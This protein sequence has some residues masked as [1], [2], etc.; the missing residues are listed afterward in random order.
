[1]VANLKQEFRGDGT[2]TKQ[3]KAAVENAVYVWLNADL[4][5]PRHLAKKLNRDDLKIVAPSWLEQRRFVGLEL[6]DVI[7][8]HAYVP[9]IR[10]YKCFKEALARI[11]K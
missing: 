1:M 8:D 6:T 5:Y 7:L 11:R 3:M 9:D 4:D 10:T 2:S